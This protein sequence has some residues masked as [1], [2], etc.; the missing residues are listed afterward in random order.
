MKKLIDKN[1]EYSL[2]QDEDNN[3]IFSV[4]CGSVGLYNT[5]IQLNEEEKAEFEKQ[6]QSFLDILAEDIKQNESKYNSRHIQEI[7]IKEMA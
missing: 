1:W 4:I 3:L 2:Y 6:G 5:N 7:K